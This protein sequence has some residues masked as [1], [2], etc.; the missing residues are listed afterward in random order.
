MRHRELKKEAR[1]EVAKAIEK[2]AER[3]IEECNQEAMKKVAVS[4]IFGCCC[5]KGRRKA[6][7]GTAETD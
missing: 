7:G 2:H 1:R 4:P 3:H 5:W 6:E